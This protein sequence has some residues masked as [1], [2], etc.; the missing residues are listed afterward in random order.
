MSKK[1]FGINELL[2]LLALVGM[3]VL[4]AVRFTNPELL[5]MPFFITRIGS[6]FLGCFFGYFTLNEYRAAKNKDEW[7]PNRV[8]GVIRVP[9]YAGASILLFYFAAT[10]ELNA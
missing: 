5:N 8:A 10:G 4:L 3:L 2:I 7:G 6:F 1:V 9:I